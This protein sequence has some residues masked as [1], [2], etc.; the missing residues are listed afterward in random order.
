[1]LVQNFIKPSAAVHGLSLSEK[2]L[3]TEIILPSLLWAVR[4]VQKSSKNTSR[5]S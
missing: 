4:T 2:E 5:I 1:M 3:S